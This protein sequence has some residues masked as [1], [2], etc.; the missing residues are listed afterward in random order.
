MLGLV[1]LG[2]LSFFPPSPRL[3]PHYPHL[4][5]TSRLGSVRRVSVS[6]CSPSPLLTSPSRTEGEGMERGR[7][8]SRETRRGVVWVGDG[9]EEGRRRNRVAR[10]PGETAGKRHVIRRL[11]VTL[12]SS[13]PI[14]PGSVGHVPFPFPFGRTGPCG[15]EW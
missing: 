2:L 15:G 10:V 14:P 6:R 7:E 5:P 3:T 1:Q 13:P 8:V 9:W 12:L 11:S 4:T